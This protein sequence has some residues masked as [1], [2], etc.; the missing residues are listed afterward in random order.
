VCADAGSHICNRQCSPQRLRAVATTPGEACAV[1]G[2]STGV[3]E[4]AQSQSSASGS[5]KKRAKVSLHESQNITHHVD[6]PDA[7]DEPAAPGTE[8]LHERAPS[9]LEFLKAQAAATAAATADPPPAS[10]PSLM[11]FLPTGQV[12]RH[13]RAR[14]GAAS[15]GSPEAGVFDYRRLHGS[16]VID[17]ATNEVL[18]AL[19]STNGTHVTVNTPPL[20][21]FAAAGAARIGFCCTQ[22]VL[23]CVPVSTAAK[24]VP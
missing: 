4:S 24:R 19:L 20:D 13:A 15:A 9:A 14:A 16:A 17:D 12:V 22:L 1:E 23:Y 6:Y 21:F 11:E 3:S 10:A 8:S 5:T 7:S 2:G 18:S